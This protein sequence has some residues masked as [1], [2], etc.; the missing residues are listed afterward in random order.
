MSVTYDSESR[1]LVLIVEDRAPSLDLRL[2][3]YRNAGFTAIGVTS[4]DDAIREIGASPSVDMVVT[5]VNLLPDRG[6]DKSGVALAKYIKSVRG[7]LPIAGYSAYFNTGEM[8]PDEIEL[9]DLWMPKGSRGTEQIE[10]EVIGCRELALEHHRA[11]RDDAD[12]TLS[13]LRRRY[14]VERPEV[15]TLRRLVPG[16]GDAAEVESALR[17][18]GYRLRLV[19]AGSHGLA[20]PF[21]VWLMDVGEH[22][23]AEVYG[24]P[25]LYGFGDSEE[26][27]V[28]NVVELMRLFRVDLV[29]GGERAEGPALALREFLLRVLA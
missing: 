24:Q 23:E 4:P 29:E 3:L 19:D 11:R 12:E 16:E 5:D 18:A 15:E 22:V 27:A 20:E 14:E 21:I 6:D 10:A 13:L 8:Q 1:P 9:F 26:D 7:K 17:D 28:S 2:R 25:I